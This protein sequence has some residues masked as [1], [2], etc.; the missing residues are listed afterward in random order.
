MLTFYTQNL[1]LKHQLR[2]RS[3]DTPVNEPLLVWKNSSYN[4][5]WLTG[6]KR[7]SKG[8]QFQTSYTFSKSIDYN[9]HTAQGYV[10]QD[11]Y[12]LRGDRGI[13][14]FDARPF[15]FKRHLLWAM[16]FGETIPPAA[17]KA[18]EKLTNGVAAVGENETGKAKGGFR[19]TLV[20]TLE[21][22]WS[23]WIAYALRTTVRPFLKTSHENPTRGS[24]L[25]ALWL[26][27]ESGPPLPT[28]ASESATGSNTTNRFAAS[29]GV[30]FQS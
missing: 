14:D 30:P 23:V 7:L 29:T 20:T 5:L 24:K 10:V 25:R 17:V 1:G 13:S 21:L 22:G 19:A 6:T 2:R 11:S 27:T 26:Y 15:R 4:G 18:F 16:E 9:S 3:V 28:W 12:N 8:L